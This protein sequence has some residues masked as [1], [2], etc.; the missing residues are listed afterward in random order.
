MLENFFRLIEVLQ[1]NIYKDVEG[2]EHH[3]GKETTF[4]IASLVPFLEE[5]PDILKTYL[6]YRKHIKNQ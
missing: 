1:E 5:N 4:C 3:I 2:I 6:L